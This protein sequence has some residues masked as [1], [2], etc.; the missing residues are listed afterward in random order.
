M[1][2]IENTRKQLSSTSS[3]NEVESSTEITKKL[4]K[5]NLYSIDLISKNVNKTILSMAYSPGVGAVCKEIEKTPSLADQMTLRGR[6]VAIVTTG[7]FLG[8]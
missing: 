4:L 8:V 2:R 1:N 6:S 7:S 3:E 5:N